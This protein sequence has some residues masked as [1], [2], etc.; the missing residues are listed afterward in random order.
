MKIG[1]SKTHDEDGRKEQRK[2]EGNKK[3]RKRSN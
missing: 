1:K 3:I 2:S